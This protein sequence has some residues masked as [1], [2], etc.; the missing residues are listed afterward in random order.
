M[1]KSVAQSAV[2]IKSADVWSTARI[3]HAQHFVFMILVCR[4]RIE[5]YVMLSQVQSFV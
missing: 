2:E 4:D 3:S 1:V 5:L